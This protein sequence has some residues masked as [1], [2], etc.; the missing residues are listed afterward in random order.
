MFN[1]SLSTGSFPS[2]WKNSYLTPI[3]KSGNRSDILNY[4]GIAILSAIPKLFEKLVCDKLTDTISKTLNVQQHGFIKNRSTITNLATFTSSVINEMEKNNQVDA[5]YTDFSKAF[6]RVNHNILFNKLE[7]MGLTDVT[8]IW[9]KSYLNN[10]IQQVKFEGKYSNIIKVTTGVPQ[11]SHLGPTLFNLFIRD[12][13]ILLDDTD[14]IFYADDL[15]IYKTI[16][17]DDDAILLQNKINILSTWCTVNDLNLNIKKC[18]VITFARK[19]NLMNYEYQINGDIL[20]RV[21]KINDLGILLDSKLTFKLHYDSILARAYNLLGFIKRRGKE[22]HNVWVTKQLYCC[23]VRSILEYGS[24]VWQPYT[25]EYIRQFESVQKQLLLFALRDMFNPKDY[26]N[27]PNY[28]HRLKIIQLETLESRRN[29][30]AACFTFDILTGGIQVVNLCNAVQINNNRQTRHSNY[31][32]EPYHKT[33]Y[34]KNEP[35]TRCIRIFNNVID[36]FDTDNTISKMTY[37][38]RIKV[39]NL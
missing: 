31:L 1:R 3:F 30:L 15:K 12:L 13:S 34:G 35:I 17:S 23:Y 32:T 24:I 16:N 5:I 33:L 38:K 8:L 25:N 18:S 20:H 11:G 4:R 9:I 21:N 29:M 28:L 19:K 26:A 39:K 27:L 2:F 36:C 14:H 7:L 22:F 37:K 6:D 10:R